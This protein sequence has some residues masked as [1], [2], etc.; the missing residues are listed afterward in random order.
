[1]DRARRKEDAT[2]V[3]DLALRAGTILE[4]MVSDLAGAK[5]QY[6]LVEKGVPA[7]VEALTGLGRIASKQKDPVEERA[8]LSRIIALH[9]SDETAPYKHEARYRAVELD[10]R[11]DDTREAGLLSLMTL[12]S[13]APDYPRAAAILKALCDADPKDPRALSMFEQI[14]RKS[15][16]SRF[17]LDFLERHAATAEPSLGLLHE[18]AELALSLGEGTRAEQLLK[19]V[20]A[21][22][23]AG[24]GLSEAS[25]AAVLLGRLYRE[26]GNVRAALDSFER[27]LELSDPFEGF[28]RGLELAELSAGG[29]DDPERAIRIYESLREREP[30]DRRVWAPL[31]QLYKAQ[32]AL[33]RV[34]ELVRVTLEAQV[35]PQERNALRVVAASALFASGREKEGA[36]LLED[37]LAEDPDHQGATLTL[38]DLYERRGENEALAELLRRKLDGAVQRHSPSVVPLSLRMGGLLAPTQPDQAADV[39]REALNIVPDSDELLRATISLLDPEQEAN[40]RAELLERYLSGGGRNDHDALTLALWLLDQRIASTDEPAVERALAIASRVAPGDDQI[41]QRLERWYRQREDYPH[42]ARYLEMRAHEETDTDKAIALLVEAAQIRLEQLGQA[43]DAAHLLRKARERAPNDFA[44]LKR[45]VHASASAGDLGPAMAEVDAALE[46]ETR[47][48]KQRVEL[49]LLRAEIANL[50]GMHDDALASLDAAYV[51]DP[52]HVSSPL[53][54]GLSLARQAARERNSSE[55]ERELIL[56]FCDLAEDEAG[57]QESVELLSDWTARAPDDLE[58]S[59]RLLALLHAADSHDAALHIAEQLIRNDEPATL[60]DTAKKLFGAAQALGNIELARSGLELAASRSPEPDLVQLLSQLYEKAGDKRALAALL[61]RHLSKS[62]PA[63]KRAEALRRIGQLLLDAGDVEAALGPLAAALELKPDDVPTVLFIADA[64]IGARRFQ[65]AQDLLEHAMAAQRQRRSPELAL[66]RH[67]MA[68][69]SDA[70][71]DQEARLEWL[72]AALEA[73]LNNGEIASETAVI[74]QD[75]AHYELALKALRAIT[76]LKGDMPMSRAE[77]FYRQAQIVAHKGEPRRAVLWAKKAKA[78]D[79]NLP[80]V[81]A[82]L[83]ELG[84]A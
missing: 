55:R 27:A 60:V 15:D 9:D 38:A 52:K 78:E 42:L 68:R 13:D 47:S 43:S 49:L 67:R 7:Y 18:G 19:R 17:L 51:L 25:W 56:R 69:L 74:A 32:G 24:E 31:L 1:M 41:A 33:D 30:A 79:A 75:Q 2:L 61:G 81:D 5:E 10:A 36:A 48:R 29:G 3:G 50:A 45:A 72:N 6:A 34:L 53:L 84:E 82:L 80:G 66:I 20:V 64:H 21:L 62:G 65:E 37:V 22:A 35:D 77:A 46:D 28:E 59:R 11:N 71:G 40:E 63:E 73:D 14:A 57:K 76:M 70:A 54:T 83:A 58:V 39:Y 16:D 4:H 8:V 23:E 26:Q 12:L 44:L